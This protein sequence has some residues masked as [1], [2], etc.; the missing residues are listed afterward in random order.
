MK[1]KTIVTLIAVLVESI[2][3]VWLAC[4]SWQDYADWIVNL[5]I[6]AILV[7]VVLMAVQLHFMDEESKKRGGWL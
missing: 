7:L 1:P 3:A 2:A 6:V 5:I 4:L